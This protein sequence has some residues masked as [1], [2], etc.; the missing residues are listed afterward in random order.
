MRDFGGSIIG[1]LDG[2]G[3]GDGVGDG[4][5]DF[6]GIGVKGLEGVGFNKVEES[7]VG[8]VAS[9]FALDGQ[10]GFNNE[11]N[12][13]LYSLHDKAVYQSVNILCFVGC[14]DW[15]SR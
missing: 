14:C 3:I 8:L 7:G 1:I 6:D 9:F 5:G 12:S 4:V 15:C 13:L 11:H 2:G 10:L